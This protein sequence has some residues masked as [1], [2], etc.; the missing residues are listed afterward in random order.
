MTNLKNLAADVWDS[1]LAR[2]AMLALACGVF[3]FWMLSLAVAAIK[4]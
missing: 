4:R 2:C 1:M 3:P